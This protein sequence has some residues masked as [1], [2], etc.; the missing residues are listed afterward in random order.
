MWANAGTAGSPVA[1]LSRSA[2]EWRLVARA[3]LLRTW[4]GGS[5][6][7]QQHRR[8]CPRSRASWRPG[9]KCQHSASVNE[10]LGG[11]NACPY[12]RQRVLGVSQAGLVAP[13]QQRAKALF[14]SGPIHST[15]AS[16]SVRQ[17]PLASSHKRTR[18]VESESPSA[19]WH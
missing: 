5:R 7:S 3:T 19:P 1:A 13:V 10:R 2:P 8:T 4:R 11:S 17:L 6:T 15:S 9:S 14:L 12:R 16:G 18:R